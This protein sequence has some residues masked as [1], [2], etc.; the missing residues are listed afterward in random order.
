ML[1]G[2]KIVFMG[3]P[4]YAVPI[5]EALHEKYQV[6]GVITQPDKP[7]G[8]G[9]KIQSPPVKILAEKLGLPVLQ[10]EKIRGNDFLQDLAALAPDVVIVAAYGKILPKAILDF[11]KFGCVNVHASLLPKWRGASPIQCAILNGDAAT[12]ATI[13]LMDEGV[14]TGHILSQREVQIE[15]DDTAESLST[16]LSISGAQLLAETLPEYLAGNLKAVA[17]KDEEAS[18]TRMINKEDGELKFTRDAAGLE[19]RV[20]AYYP[21]PICFFKWNENVLRVIKAKIN[22]TK[23]LAC[24]QRGILDKF[25]CVGT[26]TFDLKLLEVQPSGKRIMSGKDFLN[27]ARNWK[28]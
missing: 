8:R 15:P 7:V 10:P 24:G 17:Q 16:K 28:S 23:E 14:D 13:M 2:K 11:P 25:P 3:S 6:A 5:L 26:S 20:R 9:K 27:G 4:Q 21:W 18:Y 19:R 1:N 22:Q 12:G